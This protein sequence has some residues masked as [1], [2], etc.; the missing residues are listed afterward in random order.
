MLGSARTSILHSRETHFAAVVSSLNDEQTGLLVARHLRKC[1]GAPFHIEGSDIVT[2][3]PASGGLSIFPHNG[4][5]SRQLLRSAARALRCA[6]ISGGDRL[7]TSS[8]ELN[9][10]IDTSLFIESKLK[11][12]I[13]SECYSIE[14][15]PLIELKTDMIIGVESLVRWPGSSPV[16]GPDAIIPI[17]EHTGLI[18]PLGEWVLR[19]ASSQVKVSQDARHENLRLSVNV[20]PYQLRERNFINTVE[21]ILRSTNFSPN[22]LELKVTEGVFCETSEPASD[23]LCGLRGVGIRLEVDSFG[24][25]NSSLQHLLRLP[26]DPVKLDRIFIDS[27][28]TDAA[29]ER[30]TGGVIAHAHTLGMGVVAEG[31]EDADQL[32]LLRQQDCDDVQGFVF[33]PPLAAKNLVPL[34][35]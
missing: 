21:E 29:A 18:N 22:H 5:R 19:E 25:E 12:A 31:V 8:T 14:Y 13:G 4:I 32:A 20:S 10:K 1:L 7:E 28:A 30:N 33:S 27:L 34:F 6:K 2:T 16:V 26:F 17:A 9:R 15:Q 35:S 23:T 11:N 3:S 24:T